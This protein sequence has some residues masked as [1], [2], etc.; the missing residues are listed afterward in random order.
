MANRWNEHMCVFGFVWSHSPKKV[1]SRWKHGITE[2]WS[3]WLFRQYYLMLCLPVR[4]ATICDQSTHFSTFITMRKQENKQTLLQLIKAGMHTTW[5][6]SDIRFT[7]TCI[8]KLAHFMCIRTDFI[9]NMSDLMRSC[10]EH[11]KRLALNIMYKYRNDV[12]REFV[13][14]IWVPI[15]G[16][17]HTHLEIQKPHHI[18][19]VVELYAHCHN[20]HITHSHQTNE[21]IDAV[22]SLDRHTRCI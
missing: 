9:G 1:V 14:C 20:A 19:G 10:T 5:F 7:F 3:G 12:H 13:I 11:D 4:L 17:M 6:S 16:V 2:S 8:Y 21:K 18:C 22:K 15:F